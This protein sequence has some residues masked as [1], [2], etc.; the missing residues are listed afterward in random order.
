[1]SYLV[2]YVCIVSGVLC[3]SHSPT[4]RL[5]FRCRSFAR[6]I[7]LSTHYRTRKITVMLH[8]IIQRPL[9][10]AFDKLYARRAAKFPINPDG[11]L[12]VRHPALILI[13]VFISALVGTLLTALIVYMVLH[14]NTTQTPQQALSILGSFILCVVIFYGLAVWAYLNYRNIYVETARDYVEQRNAFGRI[15]RIYYSEVSAYSYWYEYNNKILTLFSSDGRQV[16][17]RPKYTVG[18]VCSRFWRLGCIT[19]AGLTRETAAISTL[20]KLR[21]QT[22]SPKKL[23][24]MSIR[25]VRTC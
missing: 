25:S 11:V 2:W 12:R 20:S 8:R 6:R 16:S 3:R 21:Q 7:F 22:V 1:M 19:P 5:L 23:S 14:P 9:N 13:S 4:K 17:F 18:S 15:T 10:T 24:G